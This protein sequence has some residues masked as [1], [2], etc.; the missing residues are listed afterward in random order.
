MWLQRVKDGNVDSFENLKSLIEENKLQNT[1]IP[2]MEAHISALM[3]D[4]KEYDWICDAFS[5]TQP[6]DFSTGGTV[7]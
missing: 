2:C 1:V 7:H 6:A 5:A 4:P 3:Q